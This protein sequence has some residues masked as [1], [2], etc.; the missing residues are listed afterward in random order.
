[1][2]TAEIQREGRT[3]AHTEKVLVRAGEISRVNFR[4]MTT[5]SSAQR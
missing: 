3:I 4:D 1:M 2:I 5:A